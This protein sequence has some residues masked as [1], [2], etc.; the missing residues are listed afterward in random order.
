MKD[1]FVLY[2]FT[3]VTLKDSYDDAVERIEQLVINSNLTKDNATI[4]L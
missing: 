4:E 3:F 1:T 2:F